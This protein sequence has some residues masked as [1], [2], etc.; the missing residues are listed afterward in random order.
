MV[1]TGVGSGSA[2]CLRFSRDLDK[3]EAYSMGPPT[4]IYTIT[5]HFKVEGKYGTAEQK[6]TLGNGHLSGRTDVA[7]ANVVGD[8]LT[9]SRWPTLSNSIFFRKKHQYDYEADPTHTLL[10]DKE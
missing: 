8:L 2:H 3:Y 1:N 4:L 6:L 5:V 9:A 10:L 7:Y